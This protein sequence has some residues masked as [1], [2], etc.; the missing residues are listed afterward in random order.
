MI[1]YKVI[2]HAEDQ[3]QMAQTMSFIGE[4][5]S[6][7][8]S[9]KFKENWCKSNLNLEEKEP[10]IYIDFIFK[11]YQPIKEVIND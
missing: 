10:E 4:Q 8:I 5:S 7:Y 1:Y 2:G 11:S 3:E 6:D 9:Y